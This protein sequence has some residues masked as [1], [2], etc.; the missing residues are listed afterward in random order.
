MARWLS[1]IVALFVLLAVLGVV[2]PAPGLADDPVVPYLDDRA[3]AAIVDELP[4]VPEELLPVPPGVPLD[5]VVTN[6]AL[7]ED[8]SA[9]VFTRS[10]ITEY[11]VNDSAGILSEVVYRL[12]EA[13]FAETPSGGWSEADRWRVEVT[14]SIVF[15]DRV[16][17]VDRIVADEFLD[18]EWTNARIHFVD[19]TPDGRF[20]SFLIE[21]EPAGLS[22]WSIT[23]VIAERNSG[24]VQILEPEGY[25]AP[26]PIDAGIT[27]DGS[28]VWWVVSEAHDPRGNRWNGLGIVDRSDPTNRHWLRIDDFD[29][30]PAVTVTNVYSWVDLRGPE[31]MISEPPDIRLL[32]TPHDTP[33]GAQSSYYEGVTA[34]IPPAW[35][36]EQPIGCGRGG[37]NGAT[38]ILTEHADAQ[39][40]SWGF[41]SRGD[42]RSLTAVDLSGEQLVMLAELGPD[43]V[44]VDAVFGADERHVGALY[45]TTTGHRVIRADLDATVPSCHGIPATITA[46]SPG[47]IKGTNDDDVIV[48]T[49][50]VDLIRAAAGN[51]LICSGAGDD[52]VNAGPGN[53]WVDGGPGDDVLRGKTGDDRLYG[54]LGDDHSI[55]AAGADMLFERFGTNRL[56]GGPGN[57]HLQTLG[58]SESRMFGNGGNDTLSSALGADRLNGGRG[59]DVLYSGRSDDWVGGGPGNDILDDV[60]YSWWTDAPG[61]Y[62]DPADGLDVLR[63][64]PGADVIRAGD[65]MLGGAGDDTIVGLS[66]GLERALIGKGGAGNDL[67]DFGTVFEGSAYGG[68]GDDTI[69]ATTGWGGTGDDT[70]DAGFVWADAFLN[71]GPDNDIIT[72]LGADDH[73]IGHTGADVI[74]GGAGSDT[75][76]GG[77]GPDTLYGGDDPDVVD[78]GGNYDICHVDPAEDLEVAN[79]ERIAVPR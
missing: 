5:E 3:A 74:R 51:D 29:C 65:V 43:D 67:I 2:D 58:V 23:L 11:L 41:V 9:V 50:G 48:G 70:L 76:L 54:S 30:T 71:G 77:V 38:V 28:V 26:V 60:T 66:S 62:E 47:L 61:I 7:T 15:H 20:A 16:T 64:G 6:A 55:G 12:D 27:D 32:T 24:L 68:A 63:G 75:I 25:W 31:G 73:L 14:D 52:V 34:V 72:G 42:L 39:Q 53:D 78:G 37:S 69:V 57:D 21:D 18:P 56:S 8:G 40:D 35:I 36:D 19:V 46:T 33:G 49:D 59:D 1:T 13:T 45:E 22:G 10:Q 17:G 79:C 4:L 44:F